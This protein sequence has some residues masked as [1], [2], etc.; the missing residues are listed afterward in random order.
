MSEDATQTLGSARLAYYSANGLPPDGG[1]DEAWVH[2]KIGPIPFAFPNSDSRRAL[3]PYHDLHHMVTGYRTD[4]AGEARVGAWEIG[5]GMRAATGVVLDLL[6]WGFVVV[7]QPRSVFRAFLRGRSSCNLMRYTIDDSLL[8]RS[9][10][11]MRIELGL[12][13]AASPA[14]GSDRRAFAGWT[15]LALAVA[16]WPLVPIAWLLRA[17]LA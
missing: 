16:W 12:D 9:V 13:A 6:V 5:S 7:A 1:I 15:L 3:V 11:E 4:L 17:L 2:A 8:A 10:G 14:T